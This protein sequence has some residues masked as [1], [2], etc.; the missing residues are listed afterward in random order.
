MKDQRTIKKEKQRMFIILGD[1]YDEHKPLDYKHPAGSNSECETC[2]RIAKCSDII[3]KLEKEIDK[4][5]PKKIKQ[6]SLA[7]YEPT[8]KRVPIKVNK[9]KVFHVRTKEGNEYYYRVLTKKEVLKDFDKDELKHLELT[10]IEES[11]WDSIVLESGKQGFVILQTIIRKDKTGRI[12]EK[13]YSN[14]KSIKECTRKESD[15]FIFYDGEN[16]EEVIV[17]CEPSPAQQTKKR[18]QN[19]YRFQTRVICY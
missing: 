2:Q 16:H 18:K 5:E 15:D 7:Y 13:S 1:L 10:V 19:S 11:D 4:L 9:F 6:A 3:N 17:F 12:G 8:Q 14:V